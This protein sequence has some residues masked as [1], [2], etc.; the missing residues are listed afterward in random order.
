MVRT[1]NKD[2]IKY[3]L[4]FVSL[5]HV[6]VFVRDDCFNAFLVVLITSY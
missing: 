4:F 6:I 1:D 2:V 5:V 3:R